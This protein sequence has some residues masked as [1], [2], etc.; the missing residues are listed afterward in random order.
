[1]SDDF[2][3]HR[4]EFDIEDDGPAHVIGSC[5]SAL[6]LLLAL[7]PSAFDAGQTLLLRQAIRR[8]EQVATELRIEDGAA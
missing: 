4:Y 2:D 7:R 3:L 6:S 5:D 1:M 8:L